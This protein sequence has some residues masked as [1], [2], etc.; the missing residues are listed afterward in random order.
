[1]NDHCIFWGVWLDI[2]LVVEVETVLQFRTYLVCL[3]FKCTLDSWSK[4]FSVHFQWQ[5]QTSP[6]IKE[7]MYLW[8]EYWLYCSTCPIPDTKVHP[9][10]DVIYLV[11]FSSLWTDLAPPL[12]LIELMGAFL[13]SVLKHK[14]CL[15]RNSN[16][17]NRLLCVTLHGINPGYLGWINM[18]LKVECDVRVALIKGNQWWCCLSRPWTKQWQL[19]RLHWNG[20]L[21]QLRQSDHHR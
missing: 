5:Q 6:W 8:V 16:A 14:T 4:M 11:R 1:M 9:K 17:V 3:Y 10:T 2:G 18:F 7:I 12:K 20:N 13:S 15:P 19:Q 21:L